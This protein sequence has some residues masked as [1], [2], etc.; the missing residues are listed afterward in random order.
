M[1]LPKQE[2]ENKINDSNNEESTKHVSSFL[3]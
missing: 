2:S 1:H 3:H